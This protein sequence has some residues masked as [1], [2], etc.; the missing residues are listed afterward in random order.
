MERLLISELIAW[1]AQDQR[2]PVLLDGARQTGKTYLVEQCFGARYFRQVIK[3]DFLASPQLADI[4]KENIN[5]DNILF[6]IQLALNVEFDPRQDLLFFDEIGECQR[7]LDSL[8]F[9]A[10]ARPDLYICASGSN[11]GLVDSFPVGKVHFLELFPLC[12]EEFLMASGQDRLVA[13]FRE[14]ARQQI[15]HNKLWEQLLDYYFVGGMPEVV[16]TWFRDNDAGINPRCRDISRLH[17]DLITGYR[18]DFG[19]YAGRVNAQHI[20]RV[21]N[22]VPHQLSQYTN[23]SVN[24]YRFSGVIEK[25]KG[26]MDLYGPI[27]WLEKSKLVSK[28]YPINAEPCS[29]LA[30]YKKDNIFKLFLFDVGLLGHMLGLNY[31]EHRAQNFA[32][33]GYLAEN[34]VQNE[35]RCH[36]YYPTYA[37]ERREAEIEFLY[38]NTSGEIIPVEVKSGQRTQAKSLKSYMQQYHPVKTVK[39]VGAAGGTQNETD[40]VWPVYYAAKLNTL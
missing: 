25:K 24:R 32:Y 10:E 26:Y 35:L 29:P 4:F 13:Q 38:K 1:K 22:S 3:L 31:A 7:A 15:V 37:W 28:C 33:K 36:G 14:M 39:L 21:F 2:K 19:K 20:E 12:F 17:G 11:I 40:L 30:A 8:K 34:F 9:F 18:R 6:N 27:E 23:D 5:P 16:D